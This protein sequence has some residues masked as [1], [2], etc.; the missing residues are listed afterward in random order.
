MGLVHAP[1]FL[2]AWRAWPENGFQLERLGDAIALT[3]VM[4]FF[5]L[6]VWDVA[7]LR[8]HADRR[9]FIALCV[10]VAMLHLDVLQATD[11]PTMVPLCT[12]MVTATWLVGGSPCVRRTIREMLSSSN[13][14]L[15]RCSLTPSSTDTVWL[16]V[17][18]P[19]CWMLAF[20]PFLLRAPP[21]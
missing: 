4:T 3:L 7:F 5:I 10:V 14:T 11:K 19:R 1:A 15:K 17:V 16:D 13:P 20:R 21:V 2:G 6:K 8:F 9:S 18:H 12:A